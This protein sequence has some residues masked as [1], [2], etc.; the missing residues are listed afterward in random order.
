MFKIA[1]QYDLPFFRNYREKLINNRTAK[2]FFCSDSSP[3]FKNLLKL[4]TN[5]IFRL[6]I[7]HEPEFPIN[8]IVTEKKTEDADDIAIT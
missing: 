2:I 5:Q 3:T 8:R 1:L 4:F 7:V 6:T